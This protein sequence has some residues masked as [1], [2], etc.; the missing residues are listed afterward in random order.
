M[1]RVVASIGY[2]VLSG[3]SGGCEAPFVEAVN[4]GAL[5]VDVSAMDHALLA[6]ATVFVGL[7]WEAWSADLAPLTE[8]ATGD[9]TAD[10]QLGTAVV[11]LVPADVG[12]ADLVDGA[13][14]AGA[15]ALM[16]VHRWWT[17]TEIEVDWEGR[18]PVGALEVDGEVSRFGAAGAWYDGGA[19]YCPDTTGTLTL[20]QWG[21]PTRGEGELDVL[22]ATFQATSCVE[23]AG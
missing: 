19:W 21:P 15:E 16:F 23:E 22:S 3:A 8:G 10:G 14:P 11:L 12:C 2:V 1:R 6:S 18:Y 4:P 13:P 5:P 17:Y 7:P 20:D 9:L